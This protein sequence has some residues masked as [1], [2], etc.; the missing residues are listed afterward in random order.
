MSSL[1]IIY[2][3]IKQLRQQAHELV[4]ILRSHTA[5]R[6]ALCLS[7]IRIKQQQQKL[8]VY[9]TF[10][11]NSYYR[12]CMFILHSNKTATT[13]ALCLSYI[14]IKQLQQVLCLSYIRI[15]Q[16]PQELYVYHTLEY[17]SYHRN[18]CVCNLRIN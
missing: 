12:S 16:L 6:G 7:Y 17:T 2:L 5:T 11:L 9:H 18:L 13:G 14:R 8:Y 15:K 10:E 1:Y 4:C 3:Q